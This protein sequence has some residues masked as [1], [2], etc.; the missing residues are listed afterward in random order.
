MDHA[1]VLLGTA[2]FR[3][4]TRREVEELLP[5]VRRV[6]FARGEI[7][8][9]EGEA[10]TALYVVVTGQL[11]SYR[12]SRDGVELIL[13][14]VPSGDSTGEVGLF[15]PG[16]VRLVSVSAME[17]TV[18]LTI[19]RAPLL[20]FMTRHPP[21]MLRMLES[22]SETAGRAAH[23]LIDVAFED[24]R[25]RVARALLDLVREH[26]EP[27]GVGVR[28]RLKLSQST[29]ASMVAASRENVNRALGLLMSSGAVS[30]RDGY[31]FVHDRKALED[32]S[33]SV[34]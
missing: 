12:V 23:S 17:P 15:H 34:P 1:D 26:G 14:I 21:A 30:Q 11:R 6:T 7:L 13:E 2:I 24:I 9:N 32:G 8:W 28:I 29:L 27:A 10:A 4:L 18:C 31:F 33:Q 19:D 3:D 20:A 25:A 22:L 16:G 5:A